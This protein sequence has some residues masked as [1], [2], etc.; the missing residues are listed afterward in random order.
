VGNCSGSTRIAW[1]SRN[2]HACSVNQEL[3]VNSEI[4][5]NEKKHPGDGDLRKR[6]GRSYKLFEETIINLQFDHEG[7]IFEWKFSKLSGWYLICSRKKRR[8]FYLIPKEKNFLW[9]M[10]LGGRAVAFIKKGSFPKQIGEMLKCAKKYPEGTL[11][12]F[13]KSNFE[14]EDMLKLLKVKIEN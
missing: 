13:D 10:I 3:T 14:V 7:I 12:E 5:T 1:L 4:F 2:F 6:L 11:L 9:R 8:L